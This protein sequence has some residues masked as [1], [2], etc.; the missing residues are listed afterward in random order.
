AYVVGDQ[1]SYLKVMIRTGHLISE[2]AQSLGYE[3]VRI[4]QFRTRFSTATKSDLNEEVVILRWR[5]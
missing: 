2:I 1:A 3:F 5:G 4:D